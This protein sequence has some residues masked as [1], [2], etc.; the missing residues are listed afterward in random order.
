MMLFYFLFESYPTGLATGFSKLPGVNPGK[1]LGKTIQESTEANA[2]AA[3]AKKP[4]KYRDLGE[5]NISKGIVT[6]KDIIKEED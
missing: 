3:T 1:T 2:T 5:I 4:T 6:T